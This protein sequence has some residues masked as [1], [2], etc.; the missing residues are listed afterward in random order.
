MS[1]ILRVVNK[2]LV[3]RGRGEKKKMD[4]WEEGRKESRKKHD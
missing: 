4:G 2:Y 1:K 3:N